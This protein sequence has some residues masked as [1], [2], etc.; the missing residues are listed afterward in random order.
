MSR[1]VWILLGGLT[2]TAVV[3]FQFKQMADLRREVAGM[4]AEMGGIVSAP[5]ATP[6]AARAVPQSA[7]FGASLQARLGN[8]ERQVTDLAKI[9][10]ALMERGLVPP[11][12]DRLAEMQQRF[13]DSTASDG[14]RLRSL[15]LLRRNG[16]VND[17]VFNLV[18]NWLQTSTNTRRDLLQ[19]I[20]G[21]TNAALKQPL[22]DMLQT[23][24]V[25]NVREELVDVLRGFA[26]DPTVEAKLWEMA[27]S[28][29]SGRV[30][31]EAQEA[32]TEGRMTPER[33]ERIRQRS[34]DPNAPLDER[35]LS[36]RALRESDV[37][38]PEIISEMAALAQNSPDPVV[39]AK[40]Y[41]SFDGVNDPTL[42]APLVQGL[43]D[44]NPVVRENAADALG[45]FASDP[46][47]Q[48]WLNHVI[49]NDTDPRVKREAYSALE[50]NQRRGR[51]G[52]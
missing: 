47:I 8:L 25:G 36:L 5:I 38:V 30:R 11:S 13:F 21:V 14:D 27:L 17:E 35:L 48:E 6:A 46:R 23:E 22:L 50:Q 39:R 26:D 15:R 31:E 32:F 12:Q 45:T 19:Q 20:D 37:Q 33:A 18:V 7:N 9:S 40:L 28:D 34:A 3:G 42:M 16:Q 43:Q 41:E 1:N 29:S 4:R 10:E 52:R 2:A 24:T 51:R 49:Q 44:P